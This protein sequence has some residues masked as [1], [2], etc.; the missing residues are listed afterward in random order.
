M[1]CPYCEQLT[2][3]KGVS[4]KAVSMWTQSGRRFY[5]TKHEDI[6]YFRRGRICLTCERG[7]LSA[8]TQESFLSELV[9]LR[10]ALKD[11]K[12]SAENYA[13][14]AASASAALSS[15][16]ESLNALKALDIYQKSP[17]PKRRIK[18]RLR[19]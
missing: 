4:P 13:A 16:T 19:G 3:C 8:E 17:A 9:E 7:F 10:D 6:H 15:L 14:E 12:A 11:V 18:P 2:Y 5:K 1:W